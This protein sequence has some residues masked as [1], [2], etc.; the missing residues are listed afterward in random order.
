MSSTD[1]FNPAAEK[2]LACFAGLSREDLQQKPS[3]TAWSRQQVVQH[4]LLAYSG[5][6][7]ELD[8]RL[9]KGTVTHRRPTLKQRI[10]QF[11]LIR[12]GHFPGGVAVPDMVRPERSD[13]PPLDGPA[14]AA[15]YR[16]CIADMDQAIDRAQAQ[17]GSKTAVATH[18]LLGPLNT[19]QWRKFHA[20]HT[21]HHVK[22][23]HRIAAAVNH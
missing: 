4:L 18:P 22:Q 19:W 20:V 9:A 16:H 1:P 12:C 7:Q 6:T 23:M 14:L 5:T 3:A 21:L 17:W 8:R 2:L 11:T 13:L 10:G 15:E